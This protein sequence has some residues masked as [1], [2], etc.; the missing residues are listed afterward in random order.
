MS[1]HFTER[2]RELL[3]LVAACAL[4]LNVEAYAIGGFV[5]DKFLN[6]EC[7]DIDIVCV[8]EVD[9]SRIDWLIIMAKR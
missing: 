1:L 4:E 2:E 9:A 8:E 6:R 3:Q 5:R 7:K